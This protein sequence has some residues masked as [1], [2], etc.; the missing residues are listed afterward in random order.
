MIITQ[1]NFFVLHTAMPQ[2]SQAL[3]EQTI[4]MLTAGMSTRAVARK[5]NVNFSTISQCCF[6]KFGNTSNRHHNHV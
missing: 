1:V 5:L 2:M 6:L 4:G 3:R